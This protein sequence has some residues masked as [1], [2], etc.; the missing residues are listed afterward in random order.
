MPL[1]IITI[2]DGFESSAV[3]AVSLPSVERVQTYHYDLVPVDI[4]NGFVLLPTTPQ[5]PTEAVLLWNGVNQTY[6]VD[7]NCSTNKIFFLAGLT[8]FLL[9][10]DKLTIL[11]S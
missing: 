4:I 9:P 2:S 8:S 6:G 7:F 1:K 5:F 11:F 10:G 3:P